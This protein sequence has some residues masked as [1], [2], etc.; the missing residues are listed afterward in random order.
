MYTILKE[1]SIIARTALLHLLH[2]SL[3]RESVLTCTSC[4]YGMSSVSD[5]RH[6]VLIGFCELS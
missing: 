6:V 2:Y 4:R 1:A 3:E 5:G